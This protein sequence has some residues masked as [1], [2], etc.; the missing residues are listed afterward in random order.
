MTN[1]EQVYNFLNIIIKDK[2][3]IN[4]INIEIYNFCGIINFFVSEDDLLTFGNIGANVITF[5]KIEHGDF[6]TNK[7]L[8]DKI[9]SYLIKKNISPEVVV[10]P[11]CGKGNFIISS[12][13]HFQN[14]KH[15][16]GIELHKP[17]ILETKLKI[18]DFFI[19]NPKP[20][21][22]DIS[23]IQCN[24][25]DFDFNKISNKF[26][27]NEI[28]ILGNP[29]WVTNSKLGTL[30]SDNLP[31]KINT[32]N[33]NG[34]DAITGKGN[35]DIAENITENLLQC[36]HNSKG[37]LVLLIKNSVIKNI[38]HNQPI[39]KFN[40]SGIEKMRIDS[41]KEFNVSVE[42]SLLIT[43]F[44]TGISYDCGDYDF[45]NLH[46]YN[47]FGWIGNKFVSNIELYSNTNDIDT[48]SP[49]VWRQGLKHDCSS[50]MDIEK[51]DNYFT[52]KNNDIFHLED[53]MV[54]GFLKSSDLK[55][56]IISNPRKYT[57]VTQ[58]KIG[59]DT[60]C[61]RK[62]YPKTF[63]YLNK[64]KNIFDARKSSIYNNKPPF[65]IFGIGDYSFKPYK[66]AISGFYKTYFFTLVLPNENKPVMLDDT[67][68]FI[69]F[70]NIEYAV[71]SLIL[72]N[73]EISR[74]FLHSITFGD[75]KRI[76]TKD[77]LMRVGIIE[78]SKKI[79]DGYFKNE[80]DKINKIYGLD[81]SLEL[82]DEYKNKLIT[83]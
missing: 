13:K 17:Y 8:T 64:N 54:Y 7:E 67:C 21:K 22:P 9:T 39:N 15:I 62:E 58:K 10:E 33:V 50:I 18:V 43:K 35:F 27:S 57:I 63:D 53:G 75:A 46:Y 52:N 66:V 70:D 76:F 19:Q 44:N 51:K 11:T 61:I 16:F 40:I 20:N 5:D 65:S 34:L 25:F 26:A 12:L 4:D 36:F 74:N 83:T 81:I 37:I 78:I 28:L 38:I 30:D 48:Q 73:S 1:I 71:Y 59:D 79:D 32:K 29:P 55:N 2:I 24:V 72:L 80:L 60:D 56:D 47:K 3:N 31:K 14:I 42:A 41:K 77:I 68:Y 45:Y 82:Y 49:F 69:G 23:I 6:Q